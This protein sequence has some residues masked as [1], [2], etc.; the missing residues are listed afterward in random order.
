M[1]LKF[2]SP[3][4]LSNLNTTGSPPTKRED[5]NKFN[6]ENM[7]KKNLNKILKNIYETYPEKHIIELTNE[8][9]IY[10]KK[11]MN[12]EKIIEYLDLLKK[13]KYMP[14]KIIELV[15]D[16]KRLLDIGLS[17]EPF[18]SLKKLRKSKLRK[19]SFSRR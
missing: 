3:S 9:K 12:F 8:Y 1:S 16:T 13:D 14:T 5:E 11:H 19:R 2:L 4:Y 15:Y 7:I 17:R 6:K 10:F 18:F